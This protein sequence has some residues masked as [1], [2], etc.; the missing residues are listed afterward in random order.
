MHK[1]YSFASLRIRLLLLVLAVIVPVLGL[2]VYHGIEGRNKDRLKA[3]ADA[4]RLARNAAM[5][6]EDTISETRQ[7][8]LTLSQIPQF[9]QQDSAACS[10]IFA[11][12]LEKTERH[13]GFAA[14]K[15][16]G[17]VFAS[18]PAITKPVSFADRPW[19][20]RLVQTRGFVIGE[21]SIGR[22]SGIPTVVLG[23]PVLDHTG[24]LVA[25]FS[26]GLDLGRLQQTL[27]KIDLPDEAILTVIDG[28]GTVLLRFP[29]PEKFAGKK[30]PESSIVN[31]MLTKKEGADEEVGLDGAPRLY[32]Y[33]TVG[34]G[35]GALHISVGIPK[36]A[37]YADLK[38]NMVHAFT[39]LGLVSA[40]A[41]LGAWLFGK[42]LII[43]PVNRLIGV[44]KQL[45]GGD[46]TVRTGRA[47]DTGE[48]GLLA[49]NFDQMAGAL[50][51]R[52]EKRRLAEEAL[53]AN[54]EKYR[55]HFEN[56]SDIIFL[57][58]R[59]FRIISI[60]PSLEKVLGYKPE[61]VI[62][63][64]FAELNILSPE[65]LEKAFS[66]AK[67]VFAGEHLDSTTYEFIARD[68]TKKYGEINS[69]PLFVDGQ[70]AAIN[71]VAR[72][73]TDRKLA[74]DRLRITQFSVDCAPEPVAWLEE[75]GRY[76][77]VN[78]AYCHLLN[79]SRDELLSMRVFNVDPNFSAEDW[80]ERWRKRKE[81]GSSIFETLFRTKGGVLIPVEIHAEYL[82]YEDKEF[83]VS[84]VRDI[85]Q[86]KRFEERLK[87]QIDRLAALRAIDMAITSS[88]D[89]RVTFRIFLEQVIDN[90][91]VDAADVL[92]LN[93]HSYNKLTF[94]AG[95]GFKTDAL[96]YTNL[97]L[98]VGYA[99]KIAQEGKTI[100]IP[101]LGKEAPDLLKKSPALHRE[102]FITYCGTP[103]IAKGQ[104][105]GVLEIF[106]RTPLEPDQEWLD[107]LE[108]LAMQA[109][110][111][112]DNARL[113]DDLQKSNLDLIHAYDNTLEG[114]SRA[115]DMRDKETEG[116]SERVTEMTWRLAR[117][118]GVRNSE[119]PH[120]RRGALLH[121]IGK[122]GIPDSIL[123]KPG[124]LNDEEWEIMRKHPEYAYELLYPISH[125]RPALDIPY[126][127]HEKWAGTGYPR[128][129]KGEYIPLAARIFA[130]V[131]VWDAL[132][133]ARP[134]RP[135]WPKEKA[136][137]YIKEQAGKQFDPKVVEV[138][139]ELLGN[140]E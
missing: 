39:L 67:R 95:R 61:E 40:L 43:S 2:S 92:V 28:N 34:S 52:E 136:R 27:L 47:A 98:G 36:Q 24:Q 46:L 140:S 42:I 59:G 91:G 62:G 48:L 115:L 114:W 104:I 26:A 60:S 44:T 14:A 20:R 55:L 90:L 83:I 123:L 84:F 29:D 65:Y 9:L 32:G 139:L 101:D 137:E 86:R 87:L 135:A 70:V 110:I 107:F 74:E 118:M 50:Q 45:A 53:R 56:V 33:T 13:S 25:V 102:N 18:A 8:L 85:S 80:P 63:K 4:G 125:L 22:L 82:A 19:F 64:S 75:D 37:A 106:N 68:G 128:G 129:L 7:I 21:Y 113:F 77:Y 100:L 1:E 17:E 105:K 116:H 57:Y 5:L 23:Y 127:H 133:S 16:N 89:L 124:Q 111:A 117:Q 138:F 131:D 66:G 6:Y 10:K 49:S 69:T 120:V 97:S 112:I 109:A 81:E 93:S 51:S 134:Y 11:D 73:I 58:D 15:P 88:L 38:R 78:D 35:I 126:H 94:V 130:V 76:R 122:M 108:A 41:L 3:L 12:L 119:L 96:R 31:A 30:M 72:D 71:C 79:Y 103:L 132:R 121:D 54:E 99:G